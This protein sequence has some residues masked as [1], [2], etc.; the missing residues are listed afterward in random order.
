MPRMPQIS[1]LSSN[2][3]L[4]SDMRKQKKEKK[5]LCIRILPILYCVLKKNVLEVL[6]H[7]PFSTIKRENISLSEI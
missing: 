7:C 4:F 3:C 5:S 6:Q 2:K 1:Y